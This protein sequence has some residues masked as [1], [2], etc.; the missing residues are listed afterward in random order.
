MYRRYIIR[1]AYIICCFLLVPL[2]S[3][4]EEKVVDYDCM[5]LCGYLSNG[6]RFELVIII[7]PFKNDNIK[8]IDHFYG[9]DKDKPT[10]VI[11]ELSVMIDGVKQLIPKEGIEDLADIILPRGVYL[12]QNNNE[13]DLYIRGGDAAGG[14]TAILKLYNNKLIAR[15]IKTINVDGEIETITNKY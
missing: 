12:M 6:E 10:Y 8:K 11:K 2:I 3:S 13:V 9:F 14:Y 7:E 4:A 15:V 1:Y 5:K